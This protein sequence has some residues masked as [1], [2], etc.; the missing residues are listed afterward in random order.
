MHY[1]SLATEQLSD[2]AFHPIIEE[3]IACATEVRTEGSSCLGSSGLGNGADAG[4]CMEDSLVFAPA[5]LPEGITTLRFGLVVD[6]RG[7]VR[8]SNAAAATMLQT[9][10]ESLQGRKVLSLLHPESRAQLQSLVESVREGSGVASADVIWQQANGS[11]LGVTVEIAMATM[12][13]EAVDLTG[14]LRAASVC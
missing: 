2:D 12:L 13:P 3:F 10:V 14:V 7:L 9:T 1:F 8:G 5:P 11:E 4:G 6:S